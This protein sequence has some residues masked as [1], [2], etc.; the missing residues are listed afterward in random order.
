M[1]Y[2]T[3]IKPT[4]EV[5]KVLAKPTDKPVPVKPKPSAMDYQLGFKSGPM[6]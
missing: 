1:T 5:V 4:P 3:K 2:Q 6:T